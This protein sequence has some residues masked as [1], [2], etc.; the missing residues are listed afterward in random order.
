MQLAGKMFL[1]RLSEQH[2]TPT[3]GLPPG[4]GGKNALRPASS[5][6][7]AAVVLSITETAL[8]GTWIKNAWQTR[9]AAPSSLLMIERA[10][11]QTTGLELPSVG[12]PTHR[13]GVRDQISGWLGPQKM[14][15][16]TDS[17]T[18]SVS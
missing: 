12:S 18:T 10:L 2:R 1:S 16:H 11:L 13:R 5:I 8:S 4:M 7:V 6:V 15:S 14:Y 17:T 3:A 9:G